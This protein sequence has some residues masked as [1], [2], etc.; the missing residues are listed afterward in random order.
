MKVKHILARTPARFFCVLDPARNYRQRAPT[1]VYE[2]IGCR[3]ATRVTSLCEELFVVVDRRPRGRLVVAV[4]DT[5][6]N[7]Q[8]VPVIDENPVDADPFPS[9]QL[10]PTLLTEGPVPRILIDDDGLMDDEPAVDRFVNLTPRG[11]IADAQRCLILNS[12]A[13]RRAQSI[14]IIKV[15][16]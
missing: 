5:S 12:A 9:E 4:Y 3:T 8:P 14:H 6:V 13:V 1:V 16:R 11:E 15:Y 7:Q 2:N 10:T